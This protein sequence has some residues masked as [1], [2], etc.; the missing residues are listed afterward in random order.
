MATNP[1]QAFVEGSLNLLT[2]VKP[3]SKVG[4]CCRYYMKAHEWDLLGTLDERGFFQQHMFFLA[5]TT[6][7]RRSGSCWGLWRRC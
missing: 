5:G 7:R 4:F 1:V 6:W 3:S 2:L